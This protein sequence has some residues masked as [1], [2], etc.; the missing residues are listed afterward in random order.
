MTYPDEAR[1]AHLQPEVPHAARI[2]NHWMGGTDNF[3]A[4]RAAGDAVAQVYPE[5]VDMA[6]ESRR[7]LIRVVQHLTAEAGIRQFLDIGTGLPTMQNTHE[8]AQALAPE[9]RIVYVD[10]DPM[11]LAHAQSLPAGTATTYVQADYHSPQTILDEAAKILDF[12]KPVAVMYMGVMGYEPDLDVVRSLVGHTMAAT[13]PGS[14]LVLWDGTNTT[15]AVVEGAKRLAEMGGVPYILR[16]PDELA[17]VF[18]GL[19]MV[20]PGLEQITRWRAEEPN[21]ERIDA[22][23]AVARK[24]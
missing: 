7:F 17:S 12:S 18:A 2:W 11:V 10:A 13:V 22:Y 15:P 20:E 23:G 4:D 6:R 3:A 19:T 16:S 24:V 1:S 21:P 5:I 8:V 14:A 9:S